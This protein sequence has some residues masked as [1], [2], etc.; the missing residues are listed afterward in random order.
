MK[1]IRTNNHYYRFLKNGKKKRIKAVTYYKH[2]STNTEK[3]PEIK[4]IMSKKKKKR[5]TFNLDENEIKTY[6]LSNEEKYDK[7]LHY[8]TIKIKRKYFWW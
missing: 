6:Y 5:V 8:Q 3:K 2:C 1:V 4:S 7:L